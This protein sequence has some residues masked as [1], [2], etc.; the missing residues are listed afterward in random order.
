LYQATDVLGKLERKTWKGP[1]KE[2]QNEMKN[3]PVEERKVLKVCR[4]NP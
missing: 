3:N 2:T 1:K 4:E